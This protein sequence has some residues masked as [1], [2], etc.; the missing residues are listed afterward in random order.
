MDE[1]GRTSRF[2]SVTAPTE[3]WIPL[4]AC[5]F[6]KLVR[7]FFPLWFHLFVYDSSTICFISSYNK[8]KKKTKN[9]NT[10]SLSSYCLENRLYNYNSTRFRYMTKKKRIKEKETKNKKRKREKKWNTRC[11]FLLPFHK[12]HACWTKRSSLVHI[13]IFVLISALKLRWPQP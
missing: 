6:N 2:F 13:D 10:S 3:N 9:I 12:T 8:K 1:T 4:A 11:C 7:T 5:S